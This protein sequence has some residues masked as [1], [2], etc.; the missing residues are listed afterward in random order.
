MSALK[1]P[2]VLA[3]ISVVVPSVSGPRRVTLLNGEH[4]FPLLERSIPLK[5]HFV[6][7]LAGPRGLCVNAML[8]AKH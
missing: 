1:V 4:N 2:Q 8:Q 7:T 6:P 5:I 3:V